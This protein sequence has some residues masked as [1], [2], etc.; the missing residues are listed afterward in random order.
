MLVVEVAAI[1]AIESVVSRRAQPTLPEHLD[2]ASAN[3]IPRTALP[4]FQA[5]VPTRLAPASTPCICHN[6]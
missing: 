4:S 3:S 1:Q 2:R 6:W 5:R